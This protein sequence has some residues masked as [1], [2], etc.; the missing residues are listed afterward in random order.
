VLSLYALGNAALAVG[1]FP[2]YLQFA[3]G[4]LRLHL[5]GTALMVVL[6]VP[7][8]M[9]ATNHFG[10]VGAAGSWLGVNVLYALVWTPVAHARFMPGL[11]G[12]WLAG[13]VLPPASLAA[14]AAATSMGLPWPTGRLSEGF[15]LLAVSAAV[16]MISAAGSSSARAL[17]ISRRRSGS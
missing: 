3:A 1:A 15:M 6:L 10:A 9:W 2:Y 16:L 14:A 5:V 7:T 4:Q 8:V 13:D 11:H 17:L 12:Q